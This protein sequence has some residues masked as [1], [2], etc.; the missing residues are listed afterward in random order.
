M[1]DRFFKQ[2]AAAALRE[3]RI[4]LPEWLPD[5]RVTGNE[6]VALN[7]TRTDK[8]LGSF[9]I[10]LQNGNWC[11][12]ATN[13]KGGDLISL[14]AY[15]KSLSQAEAA[16]DLA[17][18][19]GLERNPRPLSQVANPTRSEWRPIMP[20][21]TD[22]GKAQPHPRWGRPS[23]VWTYKDAEG[24]R[25]GHVCRFD[26]PE[27][28][29]QI[30]PL[31]FCEGPDNSHAWRW[32]GF[33]EPRPLYGLD[34][35]VAKPD[36][37]VLVVEGEK[38][39]DAAQE[40]FPDMVLITSPGGSNAAGKADWS[41]LRGRAVTIW[42]DAD[43]AGADYARQVAALLQGA[44]AESVRMV[45]PGKNL[46]QGWDLADPLPNG[47]T[48]DKL[49]TLLEAADPPEPEPA[50]AVQVEGPGEWEPNI[51][52]W[53]TLQEAALHGL[54]GDFVRL[55]CKDSE[56]DPAAVLAT[57]LVRFG[58][59]AGSGPH[60]QVGEAVHPPRLFSVVVGSSS[61][62]RKGTSAK[63]VDRLFSLNSHNS[64]IPAHTSPGPLSTGEGLVW[65][66]RDPVE[67]WQLDKNTGQG[68]YVVNDPG[69]KNKRLFVLD[70]ELATALQCT[71]REG[72]T[73]STVL[74]TLW[75]TG[76][77][78]PLTKSNRTKVTGAHIG[79]VTHIT[80]P[81]LDRLLGEV[82]AL[83]GYSNRFLWVCARRRKIVPFPKAMPQAEVERLQG[84]VLSA[85]GACREPRQIDLS[86]EARALWEQVYPELTQDHP[87]LAGAVINRGEAQVLRLALVY[88]LL[89]CA[90]Q[91]DICHLQAALAMWKY[92]RDSALYIFGGRE[93]DSTAQRVIS[94]LEGGPLTATKLFKV[95]NNH[96]SKARLA[97]ALQELIASGKVAEQ[98]ELA[99]TKP[100]TVYLLCEK[101]E[102]C[103]LS[104]SYP[105]KE[106]D[107]SQNSHN[108]QTDSDPVVDRWT[109]PSE[110]EI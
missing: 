15:L 89:D 42:P 61:K 76:N 34:K 71:K 72:N 13:D 21:P 84:R 56:A 16:R 19:L 59:E 109:G 78:E 37:S 98:R 31:I 95:F 93:A 25:L 97:A 70:E 80:G 74:R 105:D 68:K 64:H 35:L 104:P 106:K 49:R 66:V 29:K 67:S 99:K 82:E 14:Y 9:K 38:A 92:C 1:N 27:G 60:V 39:A 65:R 23:A 41:L 28:N 5:G 91:I 94:A 47:W 30:L 48:V 52:P 18:R 75:D 81:E 86:S 90:A 26:P 32:Q 6:Y 12:F 101:C 88:A 3:A 8:S 87:G 53:P 36:A 83:N 43:K 102:L 96:I 73:L 110:V 77:V 63:P 17:M 100:K 103:E 44:G 45:Q 62:A 7:P 40:L 54:A 69:E 22:A 4:I 58:I 24:R 10:N 51:R 57:F 11:D 2:V 107:N 33:P 20:V 46:S 85:L 50:Q 79:I 55:A 108:S